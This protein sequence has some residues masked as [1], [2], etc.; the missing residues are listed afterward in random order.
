MKK[1]SIAVIILVASLSAM[2][3]DNKPTAGCFGIGYAVG[4][5][6]VQQN[7]GFSYLVA[8]NL[9]IGGSLGFQFNHSRNSTYDSIFVTGTNFTNLPARRE[10]RAATTTANVTIAPMVK[11]HFKVKSN[12]DVFVGGVIPIGVGPGTKTVNSVIITAD[13][14][15][16]TGSTTTKAPVNV[17]VGAGVLL[18][19]QYF[20]Y[21]NL[22]LGATASLGF[23]ATM[24]D[25]NNVTTI[26][27]SET[28]SNNP[29]TGT[30]IPT[31]TSKQFEKMETQSAGMMHEFDLSLGWYFGNAGK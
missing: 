13:N 28:G 22:A 15:N 21:K 14:Y 7:V 24:A 12:L 18:G 30:T 23:N 20:F 26:S 4:F 16:S 25:G 17:S 27:G 19:C 6:P 1:I 31:T 9:E 11:Y 3:Q 5:F 2:A 10:N 29:N 8:D